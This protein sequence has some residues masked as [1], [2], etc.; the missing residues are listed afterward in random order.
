MPTAQITAH[1]AADI[2]CDTKGGAIRAW[3][4]EKKHITGVTLTGDTISNFTM[5][6]TG[7]W[8]KWEFALDNTANFNAATSRSGNR[9]TVNQ[10][11]FL[12]FTGFDAG[13]FQDAAE[14][15]LT[16]D[17]VVIW[18]LPGNIRLVQGI[19]LDSSA[20]GGFTGTQVERTL[21]L[22]SINTDVAQGEG[23]VEYTI[24]GISNNLPP[25]TT[26]TDTA[27]AA[28]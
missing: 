15:L 19:E 28:L 14:E 26:I 20:T 13:L 16:C 8:F 1:T 10:T 3:V 22:P 17:V 12:R 25:V 24:Q 2:N 27:L 6:S 21:L 18:V 9:K 7:K 11:G 23:R 5:A 4:A